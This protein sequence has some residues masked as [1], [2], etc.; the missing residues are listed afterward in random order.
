MKADLT[1]VTFDPTKRYR[2]VLHQQGRVQLDADL[3]EAQS[4]QNDRLDESLTDVIGKAGVPRDRAGFE[5]KISGTG[6]DLE[7]GAGRLYAE[8]VAAVSTGAT[9]SNQPYSFLPLDLFSLSL[10]RHLV[11]L[12]VWERAISAIEDP[13][14]REKALGG[15]DTAARTEVVWQV[16]LKDV[17]QTATCSTLGNWQPVAPTGKLEAIVAP[18]TDDTSLCSLPPLGGYT[19]SENQLYRIEVHQSGDQTTA[20]F[21]WSRDNGAVAAAIVSASNAAKVELDRLDPDTSFGFGDA[22]FVEA[23]DEKTELDFTNGPILDASNPDVTT[24]SVSVT[25]NAVFDATKKPKLRRWDGKFN[26]GAATINL[27]GGLSVKLSA[28]T[29]KAG[30]YWTVPARALLEGLPGTIEWP[31]GAQ[32]PQGNR[33]RY[34]ALALVDVIE[35]IGGIRLFQ[36][37]T[38]CR[39]KFPPLTDIWASDVNIVDNCSFGTAK[40]VQ[41]AIDI[42]CKREETCT[43]VIREGDDLQKRF[44]EI[45]GSQSAQVCFPAGVWMLPKTVL[46]TGKAH[47]KISGAG[48]GTQILAMNNETAFHLSQCGA[49]SVRDMVVAGG[50]S[51]TDPGN[52]GAITFTGC[53]DVLAEALYLTTEHNTSRAS[54]GMTTYQCPSV[55]VRD[56]DFVPGHR[57][58]GVLI[59]DSLQVWVTGCSFVTQTS[60]RPAYAERIKDTKYRAALRSKL[61]NMAYASTSDKTPIGTARNTFVRVGQYYIYFATPSPL[62][63]GWQ[64]KVD[65]LKP[66]RIDSPQRAVEHL[67]KVVDNLITKEGLA[68]GWA[69]LNKWLKDMDAIT[70]NVATQGIVVGG[71]AANDVRIEDNRIVNVQQGI[72]VGVSERGDPQTKTDLP[73]AGRVQIQGNTIDIALA[74]DCIGERHGI[75]VGNCQSLVV[76]NNRV[77][78]TRY[79]T[80]D[81]VTEGIRIY[82]YY[83]PFILIRANHLDGFNVGVL[84][85]P[86]VTAPSQTFAAPAAPGVKKTKLWRVEE[87]LL[88]N[89]GSPVIAGTGVEEVNN[90]PM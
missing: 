55:R 90:Y 31:G 51:G 24:N 28:G 3:N 4:I 78:L 65:A 49:V 32:P 52:M 18:P 39:D 44:D 23:C 45:G 30:D 14:I 34:A 16:R 27:E 80:A 26:A 38:D 42:L 22:R 64:A 5:I 21:K 37:V 88:A 20:K 13:L 89:G 56:C 79:G 58:I 67:Y 40:T 61:V 60:A 81:Q 10:G 72:H 74:A 69:P 71:S 25:P 19:R 87:N 82:G 46:I 66:K 85:R 70:R 7:I 17:A 6:K 1:R 41:D 43:I 11:Y 76:E 57:A 35:I 62:Q 9:L 59:V 63:G 83:G 47:L 54:S 84:A 15:P 2:S 68:T 50:K 29:Y 36:N 33:R 75:F 73:K 86:W 48:K 8:G 12:E 77:T 53:G